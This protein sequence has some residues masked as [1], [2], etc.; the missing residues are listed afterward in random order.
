MNHHYCFS[1]LVLIMILKV[2]IN[3]NNQSIKP[4]RLKIVFT[5]WEEHI[6]LRFA[7]WKMYLQ[8]RKKSLTKV[9]SYSDLRD[10]ENHQKRKRKMSNHSQVAKQFK[11]IATCLASIIESITEV[12]TRTDANTCSSPTGL[13]N[14]SP[15]LPFALHIAQYEAIYPALSPFQ[16]S[17]TYISRMNHFRI[18]VLHNLHFLG[19]KP[20]FVYNYTFYYASASTT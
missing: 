1:K 4:F 3:K 5:F 15:S 2:V 13:V 7:H 11:N 14:L 19:C 9:S 17:T 6:I 18:Y 16:T 20:R 12:K 10:E 8:R